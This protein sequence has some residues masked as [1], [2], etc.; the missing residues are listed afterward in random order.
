MRPVTPRQ[1]DILRFVRDYRAKHG[2]SPTM[3]EMADCFGLT[4]VTVFEHVG[5]LERKGL[6]RREAKH[7]ARSLQ[8]SPDVVFPED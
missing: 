1:M 6:L 2:Y 3:Q 4:K 5:A 7:R 8:I